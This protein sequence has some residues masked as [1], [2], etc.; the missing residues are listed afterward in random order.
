[1][2]LRKEILMNNIKIVDNAGSMLKENLISFDK[3]SRKYAEVI[4]DLQDNLKKLLI[5][6]DKELN[7][8]KKIEVP[9]TS[10][11]ENW[12]EKLDKTLKAI[13]VINNCYESTNRE[14]MTVGHPDRLEPS[15]WS[16]DLIIQ[17]EEKQIAD[18]IKFLTILEN[19]TLVAEKPMNDLLGC[20]TELE[21]ELESLE[22]IIF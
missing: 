4:E 21:K 3:T 17:S 9:P 22:S 12:K 18:Q 14:L 15:A 16:K 19:Q 20:V 5:N 7:S 10:K 6:V 2:L 13:L 11:L 1:M 8:L